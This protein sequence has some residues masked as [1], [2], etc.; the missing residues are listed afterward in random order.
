MLRVTTAQVETW[1]AVHKGSIDDLSIDVGLSNN[2]GALRADA[3]VATMM[4]HRRRA[5]VA[6]V[7]S[8]FRA[9]VGTRHAALLDVRAPSDIDKELAAASSAGEIVA[10][11]F[12][13]A[14]PLLFERALL[15]E[16]QGRNATALADLDQ[17]LDSYPGFVAAAIAAA[18]LAVAAGEPRRAIQSLAYI[19]RELTLT[20]EGSAVLA[21]AL[22]SIGLH[23]SASRYDLSALI[24]SGHHDSHGND[25]APVDVAGNVTHDRRMPPLAFAAE[26]RPDG[27]VLCNDRGNYYLARSMLGLLLLDIV[28]REHPISTMRWPTVVTSPSARHRASAGISRAYTTVK[29]RLSAQ[30]AKVLGAGFR[31]L[32]APATAALRGAARWIF[33]WFGRVSRSLAFRLMTMLYNRRH[34]WPSKVL[35][36]LT[37][38]LPRPLRIWEWDLVEIAERDRRSEIARE[39][40]QFGVAQIFRTTVQPVPAG[41]QPVQ[42]PELPGPSAISESGLTSGP[43]AAGDR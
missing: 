36:I 31:L 23:Q 15:A 24:S 33:A 38:R 13:A 6:E 28:S 30:I 14:P 35:E 19:E 27:R 10:S 21:D 34:G 7:I 18:R 39:R 40:L 2:I 17:L 4:L 8:E 42:S 25:C 3:A 9:G 16:M 26:R 5:A 22:R 11:F 1:V 43:A 37:A 32:P 29:F 41:A 20:R 12:A